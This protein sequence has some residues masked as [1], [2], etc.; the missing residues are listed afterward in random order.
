MQ[1]PTWA[2]VSVG[3]KK[4]SRRPDIFGHV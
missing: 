1:K 2:F 3:R 4:S